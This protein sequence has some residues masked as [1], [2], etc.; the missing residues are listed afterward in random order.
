MKPGSYR[1]II[2]KYLA[3]LRDKNPDNGWIEGFKLAK[4]MTPYGWIGSSGYVRVSELSRD[5][6]VE[7]KIENGYAWFRAKPPEV[8]KPVVII[9][10]SM[11]SPSTAYQ[12]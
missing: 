12:E 7:Q 6:L 11:F 5:G 3:D 1:Y 9:Q 10:E 8:K 4:V 2:L